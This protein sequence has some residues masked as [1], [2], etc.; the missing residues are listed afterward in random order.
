MKHAGKARQAA[1]RLVWLSFAALV[2]VLVAGVLAAIIGSLVIGMAFALVCLW[3]LFAAF[4]MYF[5][6]DP[7]PRAPSD[8]LAIVS[9][10]HGRVDVVD[11]I[12]EGEFM[13]G[14]CRRV[15]I[16]LSIFDVHVQRAPVSGK[17]VFMRHREGQF[18]SA[19][20]SDC[21]RFNENVLLGFEPSGFPDRRIGVRL[22]AGVIA[23]RIVVWAAAG[24]AVERGE[25]LSLI[26]FGSRVELYLPAGVTLHCQPGQKVR[27]GETVLARFAGPEP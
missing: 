6:R 12:T 17:I 5:F 3:A 18:L 20:R 14:P 24:E 27:A 1:L 13:G 25:R 16:F 21:G 23:R 7:E 22:I 9:P 19:T 15:S 10:A 26:Q 11:E 8:A 2:A 4:T